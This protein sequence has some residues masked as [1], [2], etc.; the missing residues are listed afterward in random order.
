MC[1][2]INTEFNGYYLIATGD[3]SG[4]SETGVVRGKSSYW[5]VIKSELGLTDAQL[6]IRSKNLG[7]IESRVLCNVVNQTMGIF[8]DEDGC[9][10][11]ITE[12]KYAKVDDRGV[13]IKDRNKQKN[14]FLDGLRY[15]LDAN[16]PDILNKPQRKPQ[17]K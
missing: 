5:K 3:A 14:D 13:L 10:P 12:C 16:W 15:L 9:A 1:D 4:A 7:L 11:L 17:P 8:F 2:R 6:H